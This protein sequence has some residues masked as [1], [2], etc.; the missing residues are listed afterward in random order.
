[1]LGGDAGGTGS[2]GEFVLG[3]RN[4]VRLRELFGMLTTTRWENTR[5]SIARAV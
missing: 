5:M 4:H 1:L 2:G 3:R